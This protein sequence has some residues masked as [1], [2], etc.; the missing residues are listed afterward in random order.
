[1]RRSEKYTVK[2]VNCAGKRNDAGAVSN[3]GHANSNRAESRPSR[4]LKMWQA[5]LLTAPLVW[6]GWLYLMIS[7]DRWELLRENWFMSVTMVMV[8]EPTAS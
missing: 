2:A 4:H 5:L 7:G 8:S 3:R 6:T 1:M